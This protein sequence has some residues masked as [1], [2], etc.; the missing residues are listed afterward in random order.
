MTKEKLKKLLAVILSL[1]LS[2]SLANVTA[3]AEE[4]FGEEPTSENVANEACST[5]AVNVGET[6]LLVQEEGNTTTE[7]VNTMGD[8]PMWQ[9]SDE[10][11]ATVEHGTVTGVSA[12]EVQITQITYVLSPAEAPV[13]NDYYASDPL[14]DTETTTYTKVTT[15]WDMTVTATDNS[16]LLALAVPA[17]AHAGTITVGGA[18]YTYETF[19]D[20]MVA[21]KNADDKTVKLSGAFLNGLTFT[22]K[23][24]VVITDDVT[25]TG[26]GTGNGIQFKVGG[27]TL[28]CA[29]AST[30][31]ITGFGIALHTGSVTVG[32]GTYYLKDSTTAFGTVETAYENWGGKFIGTTSTGTAREGTLVNP[33]QVYATGCVNVAIG[34]GTY[35]NCTIDVTAKKGANM[36]SGGFTATNSSIHSKNFSY[37]IDGS[38]TM[39]N[40]VFW[41]DGSNYSYSPGLKLENGD[42]K[43]TNDSLLR[44]SNWNKRTTG[45]GIT[46]TAAHFL[47]EDSTVDVT[48]EGS[49]GGGGL[50]IN[51]GHAT[52]RN[53]TLVAS[54]HR[55]IHFGAQDSATIAIEGDCVFDLDDSAP[56][57]GGAEDMNSYVITGGSVEYHSASERYSG[58]GYV[59]DTIPVNGDAY[60]NNRLHLFPMG[61]NLFSDGNYTVEMLG[62]KNGKD[63]PYTYPVT[64]ADPDGNRYVWGPAAKV[65]FDLRNAEASFADTTRFPKELFALRGKIW[66]LQG[67]V[68]RLKTSILVDGS[69]LAGPIRILMVLSN[70]LTRTWSFT[71]I[72]SF[73]RSGTLTPSPITAITA[74]VR[75]ILP[76][77]KPFKQQCQRCLL[78]RL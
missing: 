9:S 3:F 30:L 66:A 36:P 47:V 33:L 68:R 42:V 23:V 54:N 7:I 1:S 29:G 59:I 19:S 77:T 6:L 46:T 72:P 69:F 15:V 16:A 76:C 57:S 55:Y 56:S 32:D 12:G 13:E 44:S 2:L 17:A 73:M 41:A 37:Y 35:E 5:L 51:S 60:G 31:T 24:D 43:L 75:I 18:E 40:S 67:S 52:F 8:A 34:G 27:S 71:R 58:G 62:K 11:V 53:A 78:T 25:I 65:T 63:V 10:A 39:N 14:E 20:A 74:P 50:N 38:V 21:V 64:K 4:S 28:T 22:Q 61:E 45:I 48:N 26:T 49:K 70:P